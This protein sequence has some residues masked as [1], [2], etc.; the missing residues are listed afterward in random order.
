MLVFVL[1]FKMYIAAYHTWKPFILN[2]IIYG[3]QIILWMNTF[4][5]LY[6][7]TYNIVLHLPIRKWY[8]LQQLSIWNKMI[9]SVDCSMLFV[10]ICDFSEILIIWT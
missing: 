8:S 1:C 2:Q 9:Y 7:Y 6:I 5:T 4:A 10:Y 3:Q